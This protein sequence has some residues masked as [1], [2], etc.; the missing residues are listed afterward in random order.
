MRFTFLQVVALLAPAVV[1]REQRSTFRKDIHILLYDKHSALSE[2]P[3]SSLHFFKDQSKVSGIRT[4]VYGGD[5]KESG[6]GD[7]LRLLQPILEVANG[8][9][10]IVVA[11]AREV[12]LNV[13]SNAEEASAAVDAFVQTFLKLT[14][15]HPNAVVISAEEHCCSAAMS[16]AAPGDY[17]DNLERKHRACESGASDCLWEGDNERVTS[18]KE[19]MREIALDETFG[20]E[21]YENVYLNS[22]I[23]AGYP[24]NLMSLLKVSDIGATEDDQAVLSD[25][26]LAAPEMIRLDYHQELFGTNPVHKGLEQGCLFEHDGSSLQHST[27]MTR[28][29]FVHTPNKFYDCLDTMID[30]MGGTSQQRYLTDYGKGEEGMKR[31]L[32]AFPE[33]QRKLPVYY[34]AANNYGGYGNYGVYV[35]T[36][37][38]FLQTFLFGQYGYFS[39]Y[40]NY[41]VAGEGNYGN[42]GLFNLLLSRIYSTEQGVTGR[43]TV[44]GQN[45][46]GF[47]IDFGALM[48]GLFGNYGNY[49]NYGS[50]YSNYGNYGNYG[51]Y[52]RGLKGSV[53]APTELSSGLEQVGNV[54]EA[55]IQAHTSTSSE[56]EEGIFFVFMQYVYAFL[57]LFRW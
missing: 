24:R 4:T 15:E 27:Q 12:L 1:A 42:Y 8:S 43:S 45:Q 28:P 20:D 56:E 17:F 44:I 35:W 52:R 21:E 49:G 10:L 46:Y 7:K 23:L 22:G 6:S 40:G 5:L 19:S 54:G 25:L 48:N 55:T 11:D 33:A 9:E 3:E 29:L 14:K 53:D 18:W 36:P 2:D 37:E 26:M 31:R 41:G 34:E 57:A 51:Y 13:P 38:E 39:N 50:Y 30:A 47:Y 16:H 32:E